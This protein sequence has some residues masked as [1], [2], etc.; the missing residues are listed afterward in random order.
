MQQFEGVD[1][2]AAMAPTLDQALDVTRRK[3]F[4]VLDGTLL[5]IDRVGMTSGY[6]RGFYSGST[7]ATA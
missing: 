2:L 7:S 5:S 3:A 1:V 4:M 6:D